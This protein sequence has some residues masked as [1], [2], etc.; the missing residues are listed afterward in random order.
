[1]QNFEKD[2]QSFRIEMTLSNYD[3]PMTSDER[4]YKENVLYAFIMGSLIYAVLFSRPNIF[5]C[6]SCNS[7]LI[8]IKI[9]KAKLMNLK[10]TKIMKMK[11]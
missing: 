3:Y 10:E 9:L 5:V 7:K 6:I 8:S 2:I 4:E 1:M 11:L